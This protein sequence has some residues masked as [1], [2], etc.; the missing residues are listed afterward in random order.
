MTT[1]E[2]SDQKRS[3]MPKISDRLDEVHNRPTGFDYMRIGLALS[4]ILAHGF[5]LN[6]G[7]A[8]ASE[9]EWLIAIFTPLIVPMFFGLSGCLGIGSLERVQS[10]FRVF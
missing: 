6:Y 10:L 1:S 5:Y 3:S 8:H 7:G 4:V 9:C 2:V